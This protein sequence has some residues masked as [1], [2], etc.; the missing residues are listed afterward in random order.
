MSFN[1][2]NDEWFTSDSGRQSPAL[3]ASYSANNYTSN[4][5]SMNSPQ[6]EDFD[7]EP[8]LL[9]EL[10]IRFDHILLKTQAVINP[11]KVLNEHILDDADLAGPLFF[12]LMLG[13]SLLFAGKVHFGYIYGFSVFGCLGL[14]TVINLL[15]TDGLDFW[16]T[17]SVLGYCLIPVIS[18]AIIS[19]IVN[20]KGLFGLILS[21]IAI[22]WSTYAAARI[23]HAK[24]GLTDQYWLVLYPISLLYSCFVLITIF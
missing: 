20:L 2:T 15:H 18:L 10:G 21:S 9:E 16:R 12:C 5:M 11:T 7:N 8:P 1:N 13:A 22:G 24:L 14:H 3:T 23:F 6:D 17:C 19:I 4:N